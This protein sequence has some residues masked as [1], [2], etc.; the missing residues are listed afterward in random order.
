MAR[1]RLLALALFVTVPGLASAVHL[2]DGEGQV[3]IYPYYTVNNGLMTL[4]QVSNHRDEVKALSIQFMEGNNGRDVLG[5]NLYLK[6]HDT[7]T[8]ALF[9]TGAGFAP[10]LVSADATCSVPR[11]PGE[12]VDFRSFAYA[13]GELDDGGSSSLIR[14][15]EGH[16][17]IIEMGVV[18]GPLGLAAANGNCQP[19]LQA[20]VPAGTWAT[21]PTVGMS[22]PGGG[23]A[24]SVA[25]VDVEDGV[26]Y[27]YR[28]TT[29]DG[30]SGIVQHHPPGSLKPTLASA[31]G[32]TATANVGATWLAD[33]G[34]AVHARWPRARA[35]DAVS[36]VLARV[37]VSN[38]FTQ[39]SGLAAES[40]WVLN[41][42]TKA[43]YT[44]NRPGGRIVGSPLP[45]FSVAFDGDHPLTDDPVA[46]GACTFHPLSARDREG[47]LAHPDPEAC[48]PTDPDCGPMRLATC[49]VTQVVSLGH[50][51]GSIAASRLLGSLRMAPFR[52]APGGQV[53]PDSD[54]VAPAG[55]FESGYA[56]LDMTASIRESQEG[57]SPQGLPVIALGLKRIVNSNAVPGRLANYAAAIPHSSRSEV[58]FAED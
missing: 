30:F 23:L 34:A 9:S 55:T 48:T 24:G 18:E 45:P 28:A 16:I 31:A 57:I 10:R 6:P 35:I 58:E 52:P 51:Q 42:P 13:H 17:Q 33:D 47:N 39:E 7:W 54:S 38:R 36:A 11:V 3:L 44:D 15:R 8:A 32:S 50:A 56:T 5:F 53:S 14:T 46:G 27:S 29:I 37:S 49:H 40:E 20:W 22:P 2:S 19:L 25:I 12:G 26:I 21:D 41:F 43:F 4:L 1:N